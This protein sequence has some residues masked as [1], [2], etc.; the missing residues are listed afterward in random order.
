MFGSEDY[1]LWK[2]SPPEPLRDIVLNFEQRIS[3]LE[4][5]VSELESCIKKQL[6]F[7]RAIQIEDEAEIRRLYDEL[8]KLKPLLN[9][10]ERGGQ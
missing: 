5:R 6:D 4:Q 3:E 1:P 2:P 8:A 9:I 10:S 7:Y